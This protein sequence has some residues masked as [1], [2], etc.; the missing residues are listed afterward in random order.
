[1]SQIYSMQIFRSTQTEY[2]DAIRNDEKEM[3]SIC[4]ASFVFIPIERFESIVLCLLM[5]M[6]VCAFVSYVNWI[7]ASESIIEYV[8][9]ICEAI[10][11]AILYQCATTMN[12]ELATL[13]ILQLFRW[14]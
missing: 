3:L 14:L 2:R 13:S 9:V 12:F 4:C 11:N 1:M 8:T 6:V 7:S 5:K 10:R